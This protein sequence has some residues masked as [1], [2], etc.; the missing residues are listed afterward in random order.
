MSSVTR[1]ALL[2]GVAGV[3]GLA[4]V[5]K[6][7]SDTS[8]ALH[9]FDSR[10]KATHRIA[11][12]VHDIADEDA[13]LWRA[14]RQ[15]RLSPGDR[16]TGITRWSDWIALRGLLSEQGL[17]TRALSVDGVIASWEMS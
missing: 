12:A 9:V 16:I 6:V 15:L 3:S 14:S 4:V 17:R 5:P 1:R 7:F 13:S 10:L 8:P 2:G 11:R